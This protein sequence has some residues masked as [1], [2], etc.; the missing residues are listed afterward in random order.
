M[1]PRCV[2]HVFV[3]HPFALLVT[4]ALLSIVSIVIPF[5]N[6]TFPSFT[7]PTMGFETRGTPIAERVIAWKNFYEAIQ[8]SGELTGNPHEYLT[9]MNQTALLMG[10]ESVQLYADIY[11]KTDAILNRKRRPGRKHGKRK[12]VSAQIHGKVVTKADNKTDKSHA[13]WI[14]LNKFIS[15]I[16]NDKYMRME[17]ENFFCGPPDDNYVQF[18]LKSTENQNIFNLK[19]LLSVCQI[20]KQLLGVELYTRLCLDS[21]KFSNCCRPWSLPN[22]IALLNGRSNCLDLTP[23]DVNGTLHLLKKCATYYHRDLLESTCY[24]ASE[25]MS[26]PIE[27]RQ[28]DAVRT[29]LHFLTNSAFTSKTATDNTTELIETMLF[30]PMARSI[31]TLPFY[32]AIADMPLTFEGISVV[33]MEFGAKN[34]LFDEMLI[35]DMR[36]MILGGVFVIICMWIYTG[37]IFLTVMTVVAILFSLAISYFLYIYVYGLEFFPFMNLLAVVVIIGIGADDAFIF[38]KMWHTMKANSANNSTL[39]QTMNSTL[40][41]AL[42][43]MFVTSITTA[44]AFLASYLSSITAIRCFGIFAGT[45]IMMNYL[46]IVSWLPASVIVWEK[47]TILKCGFLKCEERFTFVTNAFSIEENTKR[48][49]TIIVDIIIQFKHTLAVIFTL[50]AIL[51]AVVVFYYPKLEIQRTNE[52]QLFETNHL[53]EQYDLV[54]KNNFDFKGSSK[55]KDPTYLRFPLRFLW[56]ILPIDNGNYLNPKYSGT[57]VYDETFNISTPESQTWLLNFCEDLKK[58]PFYQPTPGAM[59]TNCFLETFIAW[60]NRPCIDPIDDINRYPCCNETS[61]PFDAEVFDLCIIDAQNDLHQTPPT[62]L[63]PVTAGLRFSKTEDPKILALVIEYDSNY[64]YLAPYDEVEQAVTEIES[65]LMDQ[66]V[67][68]PEGMKHAIFVSDLEFFDLQHAL[69]QNTILAVS[70]SMTL[71]VIVLFFATWNIMHSILAIFTISGSIVTI[72]AVL[73]LLGWKLNILESVAISSTIGFAVDYCL[74]Y[75]VNYKMS[76]NVGENRESATKMALSRMLG[77]TLMGALTSGAAGAFMIPSDVLAYKQIG[78]FLVIVTFV[79]WFF[80]TFHLGALLAICGPEN[81]RFAQTGGRLR[82]MWREKF[83]KHKTAPSRSSTDAN[84]SE[85]L[86]VRFDNI[87]CNKEL[88]EDENRQPNSQERRN[89]SSVDAALLSQ[90]PSNSA[91]TFITTDDNQY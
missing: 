87:Q 71:A 20:E 59:L 66:L 1:P 44:I 80:A 26:V 6:G 90:S 49:Q 7:D 76:P 30:L 84:E 83:K 70:I 14:E 28:Y 34:E 12:K 51:A 13:K 9:F 27:C 60:M 32:T 46:L 19:S 85:S 75:A 35:K 72:M 18:V 29:I 10:N 88:S 45:A 17:R 61:F 5:Q 36:L 78:Q 68:A 37:S 89:Q 64:T 54:Y 62:Y 77:P 82:K 22:Y 56:G 3:Q 25:C 11:R 52:L 16:S 43:S 63:T 55:L 42:I 48:C 33:A 74:H 21:E 73:V 8:P 53:F 24:D 69:P 4:I 47:Y 15:N 86:A 40:Y 58:Q 91:I 23:D 79:S 65:W 31:A 50:I 41:H 81:E 2:V 57:L 38:C 67:T 39:S